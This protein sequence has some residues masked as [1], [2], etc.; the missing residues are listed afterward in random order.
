MT[1]FV[2]GVGSVGEHEPRRRLFE[3]GLACGLSPFIE[4]K[5]EITRKYQTEVRPDP[6]PVGPPLFVHWRAIAEPRLGSSMLRRYAAPR[7]N[8]K[9]SIPRNKEG[10]LWKDES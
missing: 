9:L 4:R 2:V 1:H 8:V 10:R 7:I 5:L 6:F 3:L